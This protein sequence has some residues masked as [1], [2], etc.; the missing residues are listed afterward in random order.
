MNKIIE[1]K[2]V[3]KWYYLFNKDY[4]KLSWVFTERGH[5]KIK[6]AVNNI[7]FSI[8]QGERVGLIGKNGA[9]KSTVMSLIAGITTPSNGE[10]YVNGSI[11]SFINLRAGFNPEFTGRENIYYKAEFLGKTKEITEEKIQEIIDF[12]DIGEYFDMPLKT[13]STG[14]KSR[15][16]FSLA[17][18]ENPDILILDEV[19]A[20]G[21]KD[22]KKKSRKKT[23][24]MFES[25]K[26]ILFSS[27]SSDQIR[28]FCD[29]VIY[30]EKGEI[31]FDGNVQEGLRLYNS[32]NEKK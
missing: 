6:K 22:F 14:M 10:L 21:D 19:F 24:E 32:R 3:S 29:R 25:G 9:G 18:F 17:I 26:T 1:L 30:M 16:G 8:N 4:K 13:Y 2:N 5:N 11:G 15:L 31:V 20:V 23:I 12:C 27:H 28:K 7:S